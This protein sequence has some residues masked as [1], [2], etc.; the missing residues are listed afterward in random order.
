MGRSVLDDFVDLFDSD[1]VRKLGKDI[2]IHTQREA[3]EKSTYM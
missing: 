2:L 3:E 1:F